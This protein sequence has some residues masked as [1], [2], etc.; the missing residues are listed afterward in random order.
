M[1]EGGDVKEQLRLAYNRIR[2][3]VFEAVYIGKHQMTKHRKNDSTKRPV[4]QVTSKR[5]EDKL[6]SIYEEVKGL[7]VGGKEVWKGIT[8]PPDNEAYYEY[9]WLWGTEESERGQYQA[10][11]K[12][13][14]MDIT[15]KSLKYDKNADYCFYVD[16][17]VVKCLV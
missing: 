8:G 2:H 1:A 3:E 15:I 13:R 14:V 5:F 6:E 4:Y 16:I 17:E 11:E 7:S 12:Y 9:Y 10:V